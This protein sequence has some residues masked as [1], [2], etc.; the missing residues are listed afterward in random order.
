MF[1]NVVFSS[2]FMGFLSK[3]GVMALPL[4]SGGLAIGMLLRGGKSSVW[5]KKQ[6]FSGFTAKMFWYIL[7]FPLILT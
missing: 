1:R 4:Y 3:N 7:I 5:G 6:L 2:G